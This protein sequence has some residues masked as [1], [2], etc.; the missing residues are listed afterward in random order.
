MLIEMLKEGTSPYMASRWIRG[1]LEKA[2]YTCLSMTEAW[3]LQEGGKY[4]L[5]LDATV[6]AFRMPE[7]RTGMTAACGAPAVRITASH[8][9]FPGLRIKADPDLRLESYGRIITEVYGGAIDSTWLD[10]PLGVSGL[11]TVDAG[12]PFHPQPVFYD[13]RRP[14][15]VIPHLAIHMDRQMNQGQPVNRQTQLIPL[16]T[17]EAAGDD[18][19]NF[20]ASEIGV[21]DA[22]QIL[23][24]DLTVYNCDEPAFFGREADILSAPRIDNLSSAAACLETM[25]REDGARSLEISAF[26]N[27]EEI[28]STTKQG[29]HSAL[30]R[31]VISRI[32]QAAGFSEEE[33]LRAV[34]SGFLVSV[35]VAH[36]LHPNYPEK[37]DLTSRPV[38]NHGFAVKEAFSQ[39]YATDPRGIGTVEAICRAQKIPCQIYFNRSDIP[40]GHTLGA[41][42]DS[43][44]PMQAVDIGIPILGMHSARETC[45]IKDYDAMRD[46]LAAFYRA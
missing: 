29:A 17:T 38:M 12:D 31:D 19:R 13:S 41:F 18:F 14:L 11:V 16:F 24:Y 30:L 26:F 5:D 21:P 1:K 43:S 40:G 10:R 7:E 35:D 23:S 37:A 34:Y 15:F 28:G 44:L 4:L 20:L 42:I 46:F 6:I 33:M 25:L 8:T 9:D 36:A 39:A 22:A 45:G 3:N 27:H 32:Y 2:S